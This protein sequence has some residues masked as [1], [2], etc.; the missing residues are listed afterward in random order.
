MDVTGGHTPRSP[1]AGGTA[2]TVIENPNF[3]GKEDVEALADASNK[4]ASMC[5][6][7]V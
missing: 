1:A 4:T 7:S 6:V 3:A 2:L 5:G